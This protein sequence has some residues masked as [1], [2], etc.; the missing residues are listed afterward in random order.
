MR[1]PDGRV[2]RPVFSILMILGLSRTR[3]QIHTIGPIR[4]SGIMTIRQC[5]ILGQNTA[6]ILT[7][8]DAVRHI[9]HPFHISLYIFF[10]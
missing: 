7:L 8:L 3:T 6:S 2:L 1:W 10:R 4:Q 9:L 5:A